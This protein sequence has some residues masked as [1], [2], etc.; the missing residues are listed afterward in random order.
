MSP[1]FHRM[2]DCRLLP[3]YPVG[4][5]FSSQVSP[6][7]SQ[8]SFDYT[9]VG[10]RCVVPH[11]LLSNNSRSPAHGEHCEHPDCIAISPYVCNLS[12]IR[13]DIL[14]IP[15]R[16]VA[17]H[18]L[19]ASRW[20]IDYAIDCHAFLILNFPTPLVVINP[21]RH[22]QVNLLS[23]HLKQSASHSWTRTS[24]T[25][26]FTSSVKQVR[27]PFIIVCVNVWNEFFSY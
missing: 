10:R 5:D 8:S 21:W 16:V 2:I 17:I 13:T 9:V 6:F 19:L 12:D 14:E 26:D 7:N 15:M 11:L 23:A 24:A 18:G 22:K 4:S 3:C 20:W 1:L 25:N 27:P